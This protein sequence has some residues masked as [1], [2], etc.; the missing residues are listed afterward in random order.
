MHSLASNALSR[1]QCIAAPL[2]PLPLP[3][4]MLLLALRMLLL[5]TW[6]PVPL[7]LF[8]MLL[9]PRLLLFCWGK[10]TWEDWSRQRYSFKQVDFDVGFDVTTEVTICK[11][12]PSHL[13]PRKQQ[14][15][16]KSCFHRYRT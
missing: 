3:L 15:R 1:P 13:P 2:V 4:L 5:L 9:T 10:Q 7:L 12:L 11:L 16:R 6:L 14:N 8:L